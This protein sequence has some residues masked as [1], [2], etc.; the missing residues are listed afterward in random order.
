M[1]AVRPGST[2]ET[3]ISRPVS[4]VTPSTTNPCCLRLPLQLARLARW[5]RRRVR[6]KVPSTSTT[7]APERASRFNTCPDR[8][9]RAAGRAM[10]SSTQRRTVE[11]ATP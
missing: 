5:V 11:A 7:D 1:S 2:A 4:S 8:R 6:I 10:T 9:A 3:H